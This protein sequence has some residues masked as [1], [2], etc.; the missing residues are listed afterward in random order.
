MQ[1]WA[2]MVDGFREA[3][4][5]KI[6]WVLIGI[7]SI[8]A[9]TMISVGFE[10][11]K[12]TF[13]FGMLDTETTRF[14]PFTGLGRSNVVGF[15]VYIL[16]D[17]LLGWVG[18]AL[19]VVATAGMF[20]NF[21][22]HGGID[23][24]LGKPISRS[25]LFFYKY[26]AALVFV[27]VQ[28]AY[29][30][31][32]TF[33]VMGLKWGVWAPG[34]LLAAPLLVFLFSYI[35]CISVWVG[36]KTRS[37]VAAVLLT[38]GSWALF[39]MVTQAPQTFEVFPSLKENTRIYTAVRVLSWIPPK[40]GDFSHIAAKWAGAG[41]SSNILPDKV[42]TGPGAPDPAALQRA[43]EAELRELEK[44]PFYS[45]GSSFL[46]EAVILLLAMRVFVRRDY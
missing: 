41:S 21:L 10:Q 8:V 34:Y 43:K 3:L 28:A 45:I 12:V 6:F 13:F 9:L 36:V 30:V 44:N 32:L 7:S 20:P 25:R 18:V 19:M 24:V 37:T 15:V 22:R 38:I 35:F 23:V 46:F 5:R 42:P 33:L 2:I 39:A 17:M 26:L 29:F 40:T 16:L 31:G 14:D 27:F 1:L 11:D 4:D